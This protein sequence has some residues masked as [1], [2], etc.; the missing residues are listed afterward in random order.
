MR[1]SGTRLTNGLDA[2]I[3]HASGTHRPHAFDLHQDSDARLRVACSKAKAEGF[4]SYGSIMVQVDV[5]GELNGRIRVAGK[6]ADRFQSHLI[7]ICSWLPRPPFTIEGVAIDPVLTAEEQ[8]ERIRILER[9]GQAF[10]AAVGL[11]ERRVEWRCSHEFPSEYIAREARAAD[12]LI[13]G[14]R[15]RTFDPYIFPEPGELLL[16]VGRPVLT[17]PQG[18]SSLS[19]RRV[20]VAWKDT[21]EARRAI[22]DALPFL[23]RAD[24]IVIAEVCE[25]SNNVTASLARLRDVARYLAGHRIAAAV[26][27]RVRPV[28]GTAANSLFRLVQDESADLIVAGAYGHS[29]VGE[30]IFGGMTQALLADSPVCC[31]LSH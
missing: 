7:G 19:G 14:R 8:T 28:D 24:E 25:S 17:V 20:I 30:W 26:A 18:V 23:Q 12:L 16:G 3:Q 4:M 15:P 29:R 1:G 2:N 6:L 21:R 9:R 13:I 22:R 5:T 27:E 11:D 31:L 10:A